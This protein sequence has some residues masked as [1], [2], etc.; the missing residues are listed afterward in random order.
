L[1]WFHDAVEEVTVEILLVRLLVKLHNFYS[2][3]LGENFKESFALI[4]RLALLLSEIFFEVEDAT[5][6]ILDFVSTSKPCLSINLLLQPINLLDQEE[7]RL[8]VRK[9]A[10]SLDEIVDILVSVL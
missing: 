1:H 5:L 7:A 4:S 9:V 6:E 2:L 8:N 10:K 3:V